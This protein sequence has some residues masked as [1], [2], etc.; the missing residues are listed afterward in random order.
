MKFVCTKETIL[1]EIIYA[2]SF[3]SQKNALS[4]TSNVFQTKDHR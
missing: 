4:I 2:M 1:T 3:T